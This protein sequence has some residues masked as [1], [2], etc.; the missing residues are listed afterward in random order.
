LEELNIGKA[1]NLNF[2]KQQFLKKQKEAQTQ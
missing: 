2:L 1:E